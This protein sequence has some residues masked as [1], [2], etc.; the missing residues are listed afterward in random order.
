MKELRARLYVF[1]VGLGVI[2]VHFHPH[3]K[4]ITHLVGLEIIEFLLCSNPFIIVLIDPFLISR[5]SIK[6]CFV[7][8][9]YTRTLKLNIL[10]SAVI[11]DLIINFIPL[12]V[13]ARK[14]AFQNCIGNFKV[15]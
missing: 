10:E 6:Y 13:R 15:S 7:K 14:I 9:K 12:Y 5:K 1:Q 4:V 8:V 2:S 11:K 3:R